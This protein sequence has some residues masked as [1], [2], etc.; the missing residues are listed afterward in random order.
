MITTQYVGSVSSTF[1]FKSFYFGCQNGIAAG[2]ALTPQSCVVRVSGYRNGDEVA[3]QEFDYNAPALAITDDMKK[4]TLSSAFKNI[5]SARFSTDASGV[6]V[7]AIVTTLLD[8]LEYTL[9][10]ANNNNNYNN[11][12]YG[13]KGGEQQYGQGAAKNGTSQGW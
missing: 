9:Y 5:D 8:N 6:A 4:A 3:T 10:P 2:A 13:N 11:N 12:G 1:D 7:P